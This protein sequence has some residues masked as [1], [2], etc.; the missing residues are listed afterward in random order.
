[1]SVRSLIL[2]FT[3]VVPIFAGEVRVATA[4]NMAFALPK[5]VEA[6]KKIYPDVSV[7]MVVGGSGK[8]RAQIEHGAPYD[9]FL[10]ANTQYPEALYAKGI[11]V[12]KPVVYAQGELVLFSRQGID[13]SSG[14]EVLTDSKVTRI[15]MANP[16]TA[17]YGKA[18]KEALE[19]GGMWPK[20]ASKIVYGES[21]SQ[22]VIY[23]LRMVDVGI[24]AKSALYSDKV[25]PYKKRATVAEVDASYYTPISQGMLLLKSASQN[26]EAEALYRFLQSSRAKEILQ[27][28]GYRTP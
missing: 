25:A 4:A 26:K 15:A 24:I 16:K 6:F 23:S 20:V 12:A 2:F 27:A 14:L 10:S 9:L 8:L 21:I 19:H 3:L 17:P 28:Y 5:I 7:E 1:V 13:L 11:G 22:T 18:A